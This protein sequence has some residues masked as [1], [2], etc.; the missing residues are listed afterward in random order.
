MTP[1]ALTIA[2]TSATL[3]VLTLLLILGVSKGLEAV[4]EPFPENV[5]PPICVDSPTEPGDI[6]RPGGITVSVL[7]ASGRQGLAQTTLDQLEKQG[8]ARGQFSN[9]TDEDVPSAQ[10]W[11]PAGNTAAVRLVVSYLGGDVKIINRDAT[12][13]GI[14]IVLGD[15]FPGVR[16]GRAQAK[17]TSSGSVCS[18][19]GLS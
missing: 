2:K 12:A 10:I 11:S 7:N 8:F 13:A 4:S 14:T 16:P 9:V 1:R 6:L 15:R 5:D 18:P 17:V 3:A 19:P